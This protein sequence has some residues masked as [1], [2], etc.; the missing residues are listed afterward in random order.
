MGDH[1]I[2]LATRYQCTRLRQLCEAHLLSTLGV[3]NVV[4][5]LLLAD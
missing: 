3:G 2:D 1:L 4:D 5:R